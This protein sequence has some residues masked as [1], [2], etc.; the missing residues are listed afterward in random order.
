MNIIRSALAG[1][2]HEISRHG[3]KRLFFIVL[4]SCR[5]TTTLLGSSLVYLTL[6]RAG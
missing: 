2:R 1:N 5:R 3:I 6:G 4:P